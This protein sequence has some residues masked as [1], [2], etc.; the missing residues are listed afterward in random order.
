[1]HVFQPGQEWQRGTPTLTVGQCLAQS[2]QSRI[3]EEEL[4]KV[5]ALIATEMLIAQTPVF[6]QGQVS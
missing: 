4:L 6:S 5:S 1:M 2:G 3:Y